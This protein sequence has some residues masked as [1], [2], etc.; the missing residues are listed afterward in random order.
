MP[1]FGERLRRTATEEPPSG[2][3]QPPA[4]P[5][6]EQCLAD[7]LAEQSEI[8]RELAEHR[9]LRERWVSSGVGD[10]VALGQIAEADDQRRHR[11][12]QLEE[13]I[14]NA[15]AAVRQERA[16]KRAAQ[17]NA[18]A[19]DLEAAMQDTA[20]AIRAYEAASSRY[21]DL[22]WRVTQSGFEAELRELFVTPPHYQHNPWVFATFLRAVEQCR[23]RRAA[24]QAMTD[25]PPLPAIDVADLFD[26]PAPP[27]FVPRRVDPR[28]VERISAIAEPRRVKINFGPVKTSNLN[29]GISRM[30]AG[31]THIVPARAAY[32]LT[33][34]GCAEYCD[35][36]AHAT[37]A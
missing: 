8:E 35:Q 23:Q 30:H 28:E 4:E 22:H 29:I 2:P 15:Q 20:D 14:A 9:T 31:E 25:A 6:A 19:Q 27:R 12:E 34:S 18:L 21:R 17:W 3:E 16:A 32:V 7:L 1:R 5:S 37:A 33:A 26:G 13:L 36:Q 11:A 10:L 24:V